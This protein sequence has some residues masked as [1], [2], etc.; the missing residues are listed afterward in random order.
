[1]LAPFALC[2]ANL[3][4]MLLRFVCDQVNAVRSTA[5]LVYR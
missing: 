4:C 5:V 3:H 2:S 1:M